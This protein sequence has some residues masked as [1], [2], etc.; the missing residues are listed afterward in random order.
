MGITRL[1][2]TYR[3]TTPMF[4]AGADQ[5]SAE[6]RGASFKGALRFWFRALAWGEHASLG[7]VKAVE[8]VKAAEDAL[9]GSMRTGQ[10]KVLLSLSAIEE[11]SPLRAG[12]RFSLGLGYLAGQGISSPNPEGGALTKRPSLRPGT[13]F[14]VRLLLRSMSAQE[15]AQVCRSL[16]ALGLLGGM[17]ARS[18][19]GFGSLTLES[20]V[21][22]GKTERPWT[23]PGDLA[24]LKEQLV[25]LLPAR[26]ANQ[27]SSL[28]NEPPYTALSDNTRI[29]LVPAGEETATDLLGSLGMSLLHF[30][31]YGR[32]VKGVHRVGTEPALKWFAP[33][34]DEMLKAAEKRV[35]P[36]TLLAAP[37]R[38]AFG[39]P[40]NYY[41][42]SI[43]TNVDVNSAAKERRASPLLVHIHQAP[44]SLPVAV[45][46]FLPAVFLPDS[47]LRIV[48]R[49]KF[50][51]D[52]S[53]SAVLPASPGLWQPIHDFLAELRKGNESELC[54]RFPGAEEVE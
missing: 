34:H 42:G 23:A 29:V 50:E 8:A 18:R 32:Q 16:I 7:A 44:E 26:A 19:R 30:R 17:G 35:R 53:F 22:E 20:L 2:A 54:E 9:F 27:A 49:K 3:I 39:L 21:G 36:G 10:A 1:T 46:A 15:E 25:G 28:S 14:H 33:D 38:A 4:S 5:Q 51:A 40:H 41:F 31:G 48:R 6:L 43:K 47:K 11:K 13:R 52:T 12:T 37:Q 45:V 24:A